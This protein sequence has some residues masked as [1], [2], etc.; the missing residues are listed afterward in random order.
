MS[1]GASKLRV[2]SHF[3]GRLRVR[4][5]AFRRDAQLA[6]DVVEQLE[7]S[8]GVTRAES[9]PTTGSLLVLYDPRARSLDELLDQIVQAAELDGV[10]T[11]PTAAEILAQPEPGARIHDAFGSLNSA[12]RVATNNKLDLKTTYPIALAAGGVALLV[13]GPRGIPQWYDM[14]IWG[15]NAF[16]SLNRP[17][18]PV[19]EVPHED[20]E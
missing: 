14:M 11:D 7:A 15:F 18:S 16:M 20:D 3:P 5:E 12:L 8:T 10:A 6:R 2:V 4:A 9:S 17:H 13:R 19:A 1:D